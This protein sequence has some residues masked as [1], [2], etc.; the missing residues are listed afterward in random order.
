MKLIL[1]LDVKIMITVL[2]L[3]KSIFE[4]L[5]KIKFSLKRALL[6]YF[7]QP[8]LIFFLMLQYSL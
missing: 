6:D 1:W 8:Y 3:K 2:I 4:T 5:G 7:E